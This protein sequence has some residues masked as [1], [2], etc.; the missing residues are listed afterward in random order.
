MVN[1]KNIFLYLLHKS[2]YIY[3]QKNVLCLGETYGKNTMGQI[4]WTR[5]LL[6]PCKKTLLLIKIKMAHC[7]DPWYS[8]KWH[9]V[10][11]HGIHLE[12]SLFKWGN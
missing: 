5:L 1:N 6:I 3:I 9:M 7:I 4:P 11:T 2:L 10:L 8:P 12:C